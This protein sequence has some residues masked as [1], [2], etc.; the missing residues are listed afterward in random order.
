MI[1][2]RTLLTLLRGATPEVAF[3]GEIVVVDDTRCVYATG[4][5]HGLYPARSVLKPFQFLATGLALEDRFVPSMGSV[6]GTPEQLA[7]LGDW[8]RGAQCEKREALLP[9]SPSYPLDE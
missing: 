5:G 8:Y 3:V 9:F 1:G 6:S 4:D 7:Q 2:T